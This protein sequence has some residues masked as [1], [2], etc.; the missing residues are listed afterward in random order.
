LLGFVR[1]CYSSGRGNHAK[2]C[3]L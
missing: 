1:I 2:R 3:I